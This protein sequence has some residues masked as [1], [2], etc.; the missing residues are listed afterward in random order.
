MHPL[1]T[2]AP[3]QQLAAFTLSAVL[4]VLVLLALGAQADAEHGVA[5]ATAQASQQLQCAAP[6][7]S[8]RS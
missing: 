3:A 4:T 7:R 6:Q 5:L 1:K 8:A 2:L